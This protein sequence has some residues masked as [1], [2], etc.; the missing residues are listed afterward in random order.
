MTTI[1]PSSHVNTSPFSSHFDSS[2]LYSTDPDPIYGIHTYGKAYNNDNGAMYTS[3]GFGLPGD[4]DDG[5]LDSEFYDFILNS[6]FI[7]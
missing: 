1:T 3:N 4:C 2:S 7:S 5:H 6:D